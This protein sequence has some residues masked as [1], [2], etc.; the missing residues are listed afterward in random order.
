MPAFWT[1]DGVPISRGWLPAIGHTWRNWG[2]RIGIAFDNA[3][4]AD[5]RLVSAEFAVV[6]NP[7]P[8]NDLNWE[9]A[10]PIQWQPIEGARDVV[11]RGVGERVGSANTIELQIPG[12]FAADDPNYVLVRV[13]TVDPADPQNIIQSA[14]QASIQEIMRLGR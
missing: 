8:L 2:G 10:Q 9:I 14:A 13:W 1:K 6:D 11:I 12:E 5:V 4:P 7:L 3:L